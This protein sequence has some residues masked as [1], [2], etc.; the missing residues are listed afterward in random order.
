MQREHHDSEFTTRETTRRGGVRRKKESDSE[1]RRCNTIQIWVHK[2][3][4]FGPKQIRPCRNFE[5]IGPENRENSTSYHCKCSTKSGWKNTK[6]H[7]DFEDKNILTK[8]Q[9]SWTAISLAIQSPEKHNGIGGSHWQSHFEI[10][11]H[12]SELHSPERW[13]NGIVRSGERRSDYY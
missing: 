5:T 9:F 3:F 8:S 7:C 4:L 6:K 12:C 1:E 11:I 10:G 2:T 13:R